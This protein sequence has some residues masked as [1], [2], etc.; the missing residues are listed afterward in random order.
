MTINNVDFWEFPDREVQ[1]SL[2]PR[3]PLQG[4]G[5]DPW[6]KL[7]P[8]GTSSAVQKKSLLVSA[9]CLNTV[10]SHKKY[11][12]RSGVLKPRCGLG[13]V[14][15]VRNWIAEQEV[16]CWQAS[17]ASSATPHGSHYCLNH[18]ISTADHW[19]AIT[20]HLLRDN[21][22]LLH[23]PQDLPPREHIKCSPLM[24]DISFTHRVL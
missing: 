11:L 17:K 21:S 13:V 6:L 16:S 9:W 24:C 5:F 15:P 4:W 1:E 14:W 10:I 8:P 7:I 23:L 22:S 19:R 2:S 12:F 18:L 20:S 3:L